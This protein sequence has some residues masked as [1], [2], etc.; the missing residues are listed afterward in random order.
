MF[1]DF[2][3]LLSGVASDQY[4]DKTAT[5]KGEGLVQTFGNDEMNP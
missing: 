1:Y 4:V 2:S 3:W 5:R